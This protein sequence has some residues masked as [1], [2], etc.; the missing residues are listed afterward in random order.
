M[1]NETLA[2]LLCHDL[3]CLIS[4]WYELGVEPVFGQARPDDG[5]PRHIL[6]FPG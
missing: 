5:E 6:R 2:K 1:V 4:A 3:C